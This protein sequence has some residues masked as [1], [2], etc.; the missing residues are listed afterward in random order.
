MPPNSPKRFGHLLALGALDRLEFVAQFHEQ[1]LPLNKAVLDFTNAPIA[2]FDIPGHAVQLCFCGRKPLV[3]LIHFADQFAQADFGDGRKNLVD[4][5]A[6]V[7]SCP[8]G[9]AGRTIS[10]SETP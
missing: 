4:I 10:K 3:V 8:T 7:A 1:R 9:K 2:L 6:G 5:E